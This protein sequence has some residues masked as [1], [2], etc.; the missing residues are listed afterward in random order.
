MVNTASSSA[1]RVCSIWS[2]ILPAAALEGC[3]H[4]DLQPRPLA[5][6]LEQ[7]HP[8]SPAFHDDQPSFTR[9]DV[10]GQPCRVL[11]SVVSIP[12]NHAFKFRW[13]ACSGE[14]V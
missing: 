11:S 8:P 7:Y 14:S 10:I 9:L 5:G 3:V 1:H 2:Y 12:C 6:M 13:E 4:S